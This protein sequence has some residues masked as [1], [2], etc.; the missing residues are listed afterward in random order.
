MSLTIFGIVLMFI[1]IYIAMGDGDK[2][3]RLTWA[4]LLIGTGIALIAVRLAVNL[5]RFM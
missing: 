3:P 2:Q 4:F 5:W 1:G